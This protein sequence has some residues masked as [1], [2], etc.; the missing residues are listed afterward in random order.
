MDDKELLDS[1]VYKKTISLNH[2][3]FVFE[4]SENQCFFNISLI[5]I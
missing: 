5:F 3:F 4:I 2:A 1:K